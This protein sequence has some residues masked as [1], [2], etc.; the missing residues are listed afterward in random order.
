M[1]RINWVVFVGWLLPTFWRMRNHIVWLVTLLYPSIRLHGEFLQFR[2][3]TLFELGINGQV[4]KLERMLNDYYDPIERRIYISDGERFEGANAYSFHLDLSPNIYSFGHNDI[5][6][7]YSYGLEGVAE[8][9][10]FYV[11]V[12]FGLSFDLDQMNA[13]IVKYKILGRSY[14]ILIV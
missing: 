13:N 5:V 8:D 1:Y 10:D 6:S 14:K 11:N 4:S 9:V 12:P 3:R 7:I 2:D